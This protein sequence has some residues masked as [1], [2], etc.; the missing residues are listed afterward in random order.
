MPALSKPALRCQ[1]A[2]HAVIRMVAAPHSARP[3]SFTI[4]A[5][6]PLRAVSAVNAFAPFFADALSPDFDGDPAV[7][8]F[9]G[10]RDSKPCQVHAAS[11][12]ENTQVDC[13]RTHTCARSYAFMVLLA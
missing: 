9:W 3:D 8:F 5:I 1:Q 6:V 4:D 11:V 10:T 2:S 7:S 13:S 12:R